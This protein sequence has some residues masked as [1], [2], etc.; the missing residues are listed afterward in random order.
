MNQHE[1]ADQHESPRHSRR[2]IT[3]SYSLGGDAM[4]RIDAHH[5]LW[6][7]GHFDYRWLEA[8]ELAPLQRNFLPQDLAPLLQAVQVDRTIVVQTQHDLAENEWALRLAEQFD[9]LAGVVGWVDL[10][11]SRCEEQLLEAIAHPKF[12]GVRHLTQDEPEDD[13]LIRPDVLAGLKV[14]AKHDVPFDLLLQVRHLPRVAAL[15]SQ[16]PGLRLVIDHLAKPRIR[17]GHLDDWARHLRAAAEYPNVFCKLS[18]VS[19]VSARSATR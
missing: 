6:Q 2:G 5:H 9:F 18:F 19:F 3:T 10:R 8:P 14:L 7:L 11:S 15:A 13:F 12:V 1:S 16:L 17:D 4:N